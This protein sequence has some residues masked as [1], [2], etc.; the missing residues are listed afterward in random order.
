MFENNVFKVDLNDY[1]KKYILAMFPYPSS[2]GLHV[3]HL[4][5]YT[6]ADAIARYY[7]LSGFNVLFPIG[8]DSFGLP[9]KQYAIKTNNHPKN[10]TLT[11]INSFKIQLKKLGFSF[12]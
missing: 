9:A 8:L 5:N 7:R 11:N 12:N 6:I 3:G 10:F 2:S 4:R 1:T